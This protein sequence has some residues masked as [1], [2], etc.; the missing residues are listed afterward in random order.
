[1]TIRAK[2]EPVIED[3]WRETIEK[4]ADQKHNFKKDFIIE[5]K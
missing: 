5:F 1:M 4:F 3:W 2:S